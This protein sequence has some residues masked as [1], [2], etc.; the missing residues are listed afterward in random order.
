VNHPEEQQLATHFDGE[1]QAG[2]GRDIERHMAGC[3]ACQ[4]Q[5]RQLAALRTALREQRSPQRA[6]ATLRAL[7]GR[8]LD[9]ED[10]PA[11]TRRA[12]RHFWWGVMTGGLATAMVAALALLVWRQPWQ[13]ALPDQLV[14][15]HLQATLTQRLV[16]VVSTDRHTVKP[17]FA[18]HADV[19]PVVA[20][21]TAS[22]YRLLGGRSDVLQRQRAAVVVYQ[23]GAHIVSVFSWLARPDG[24]VQFA[25]RRGYHLLFW[26]VA[27]LEYCAVSD[28]GWDELGV[29]Q[30][31][32]Q[33]L[34]ARDVRE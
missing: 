17:W 6:P 15:A 31:L 26:R 3:D 34:G 2:A 16:A 29:L 1:L 22:G 27:D 30:G 5:W 18:A 32:L 33:E 14:A 23:H 12:R 4:A 7:L 28:M 25:T 24:A 9:A 8:A 19:S 10:A 21:F 11:A 13:A 20:D